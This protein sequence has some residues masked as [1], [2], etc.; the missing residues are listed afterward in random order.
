MSTFRSLN[1]AMNERDVMLL[2]DLLE[3]ETSGTIS[4]EE[5]LAYIDMG[6]YA[7]FVY[8]LVSRLTCFSISDAYVSFKHFQLIYKYIYVCMVVDILFTHI[9]SH[10]YVNM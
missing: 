4:V 7:V 3:V 5:F 8:V 6:K 1:I 2:M 10:A 9:Y